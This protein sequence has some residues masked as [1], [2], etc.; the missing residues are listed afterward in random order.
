MPG[1]QDMSWFA[2][3]LLGIVGSVIGGVASFLIFGNPEGKINPAGW[4]MSVIG[5]IV[6]VLIYGR[7]K[8]RGVS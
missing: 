7:L 6:V 5:A 3:A 4:I 2:T 8:A 1:R